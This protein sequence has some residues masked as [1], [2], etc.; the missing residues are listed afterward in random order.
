MKHKP[1]KHQTCAEADLAADQQI[2]GLRAEVERLN[3]ELSW[4]RVHVCP[5]NYPTGQWWQPTP[6]YPIIT[7]STI[8]AVS[9]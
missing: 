1:R 7:S 3:A 9:N 5:T 8:T 6:T 4:R 2:E